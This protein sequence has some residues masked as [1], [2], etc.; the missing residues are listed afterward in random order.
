[1]FTTES[2]KQFILKFLSKTH[3]L[4]EYGSGASTELLS[5]YVKEVISVEHN[6]DWYTSVK[7]KN[8]SNVKIIYAPPDL[9]YIE[10]NHDGTYEQFKTYINVPK[11]Y[12]KFDV[13][14]IDG[15]ARIECVKFCKNILNDNALIFVHDFHHRYESENYKKMLDYCEIVDYENQMVLLKIK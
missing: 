3:R 10:G 2:E 7:N 8:I 1:M 9:N 6:F 4:L 5:G 11:D 12:G 13:V 15:R 14:F